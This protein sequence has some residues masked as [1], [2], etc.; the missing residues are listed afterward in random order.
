MLPPLLLQCGPAFASAVLYY[1]T[2]ATLMLRKVLLPENPQHRH[3]MVQCGLMGA[4][5]WLARCRGGLS[6][7]G[8]KVTMASQGQCH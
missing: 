1:E 2:P 4:G 6:G 7:L 5:G 3:L 8:A